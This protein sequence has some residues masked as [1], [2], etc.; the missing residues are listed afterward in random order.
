M[1]KPNLTVST[2]MPRRSLRRCSTW[3]RSSSLLI[4][5]EFHAISKPLSEFASRLVLRQLDQFDDLVKARRRLYAEYYRRL[6]GTKTFVLPPEDTKEEWA[7]IRFPI[8]VA[9]DKLS[10]YRN[11]VKK[12]IDFAFSFTFIVC[13]QRF[14][15]AHRLAAS[16]LDLPFYYKLSESEID[17]V[18][19]VLRQLDSEGVPQ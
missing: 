11:A 5:S 19:A 10:F 6:Q 18:I 7:C 4:N 13:P 17:Q 14:E 2:W 9:G 1:S 8:R 16:V 12:G 3:A 15:R